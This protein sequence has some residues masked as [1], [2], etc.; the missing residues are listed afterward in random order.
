[1]PASDEIQPNPSATL[2]ESGVPSFEDAL[3]D[4]QQIVTELE[5]G[6]ITLDASLKRFEQG[7]GLLRECYQFLERADQ[8]IEQLVN[9]DEH[10]NCVLVPFDAVATADK[11]SKSPT[12]KSPAKKAARSKETR[13]TAPESGEGSPTET[14]TP[15]KLLF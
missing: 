4:L 10:G 8:K 15:G 9:L 1:M 14:E 2:S 7:V 5:S 11:P 12:V 13:E 6:S 3:R